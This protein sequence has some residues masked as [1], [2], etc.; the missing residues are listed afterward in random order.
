MDNAV[1]TVMT[2][3]PKFTEPNILAVE[4]LNIMDENN[5]T[6]LPVVDDKNKPIGILQMHDLISAGII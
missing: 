2:A 6:L 4:A 1:K 3:K 5:I